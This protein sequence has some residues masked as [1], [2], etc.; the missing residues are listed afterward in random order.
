MLPV[1]ASIFFL[2][3]IHG[4]CSEIALPIQLIQLVYAEYRNSPG[5]QK[6]V[7]GSGVAAI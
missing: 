7:N 3:G 5:E 1:N 6:Q 2:P 4:R